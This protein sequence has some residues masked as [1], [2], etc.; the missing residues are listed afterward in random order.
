MKEE[1]LKQLVEIIKQT[2]DF[3]L[4]QAPDVVQQ[5]VLYG[6]VSG[7]VASVA[8]FIALCICV[9]AIRK[10]WAMIGDK[11]R[12]YS[13]DGGVALCVFGVLVWV[14]ALILFGLSIEHTLQVFLAPK[15]YVLKE[16]AG[17]LK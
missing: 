4:E 17:F 16:L 3:T 15:L 10:G 12:R 7:V 14:V 11:N 8:S 13:D 1:L 5:L 6:R 9:W 2:K